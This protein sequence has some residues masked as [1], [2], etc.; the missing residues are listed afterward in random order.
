MLGA[1][2][3]KQSLSD[4]GV[5]GN[6]LPDQTRGVPSQPVLERQ[7]QLWALVSFLLFIHFLYFSSLFFVLYPIKKLPAFTSFSRSWTLGNRDSLFHEVL[8]KACLASLTLVC[9]Q[10]LGPNPPSEL[11]LWSTMLAFPS[12]ACNQRTWSLKP[13]AAPPC[14]CDLGQ[15]NSGTNIIH[16]ALNRQVAFIDTERDMQ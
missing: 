11:P 3:A 14:E 13:E 15:L 5:P 7:S 2:S 4:F 12:V 10:V 16:L 1:P 6:A 9:H 8:N